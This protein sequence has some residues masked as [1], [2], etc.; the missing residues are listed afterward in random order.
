MSHEF[1]E[2]LVINLHVTLIVTVALLLVEVLFIVAHLW[3]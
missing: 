1:I 3:P 2:L